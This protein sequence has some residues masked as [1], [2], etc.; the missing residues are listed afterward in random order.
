MPLISIVVPVY[1]NAGSLADLL[2]KFQE[3]S[4]KNPSDTFEFIFVD[5][6]SKD[7]LLAVALALAKS[8][9]RLRVIKLSRNFGSNPAILAGMSQTRGDVVAVI[10]ADLQDPPELIHDMLQMWR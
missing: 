10:A 3:L 8:E 5:D 4:V 1:H 7:D 9:P 2:A 6:G